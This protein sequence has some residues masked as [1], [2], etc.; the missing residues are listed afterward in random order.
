MPQYRIIV[1]EVSEYAYEGEA[2]SLEEAKQNYADW[3]ETWS[4]GAQ[5]EIVNW[6]ELGD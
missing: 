5:G 3:P 2:A 6:E 1:R 4:D